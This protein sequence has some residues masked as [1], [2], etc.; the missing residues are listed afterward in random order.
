MRRCPEGVRGAHRRFNC[1]G[2][3]EGYVL[4]MQI[5]PLG[6]RALIL[7][8]AGGADT[9]TLDRIR[10]ITAR[11]EN[12]AIAGVTDIVPAFA[13]VAVHYEPLTVR[14]SDLR[15]ALEAALGRSEGVDAFAE[16]RTIEI[17]VSYGGAAGPDL[18]AVAQLNGMS[19]DAVVAIHSAPT[20]TVHMI[21]FV[22]GFPYLGG[23]DPRLATPR[24]DTPRTRVPAGSVGIGGGQTGVYPIDSPGG[25]HLIGHTSLQLFDPVM[26]PPALLR[27]GDHVRF[28]PRGFG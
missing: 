24:R 17:P 14:R 11:I 10:A 22:P 7:E 16:A 27:V 2:A 9:D 23:L 28:I 26:E 21:G 18:E 6:D 5:Q 3:P 12:A 20:Y 19:A 15:L 8:V 1:N 4:P 25:W 13:S